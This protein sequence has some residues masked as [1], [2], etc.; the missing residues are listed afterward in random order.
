M[1]FQMAS[2][3]DVGDTNDQSKQSTN[4]TNASQLPTTVTKVEPSTSNA[5]I[6]NDSQKVTETVENEPEPK[7]SV[8]VP[9]NTVDG[10]KACDDARYRKFF[11]MVQFGVPP[12][13]V[14][15]KMSVEGLDPNVLE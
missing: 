6:E 14:K 5:N 7:E 1:T 3:P 8:D 12:P 10:I 2:V 11:K 4:E 13:A 15:L 9:D